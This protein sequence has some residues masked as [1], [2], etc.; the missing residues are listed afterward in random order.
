MSMNSNI[1]S[2]SDFEWTANSVN[3]KATSLTVGPA[4]LGIEGASIVAVAP[5][6]T[7]SMRV[8]SAES[9]MAMERCRCAP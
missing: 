5:E 8:L 6:P 9:L 7:S 3:I 2:A 1:M 4:K